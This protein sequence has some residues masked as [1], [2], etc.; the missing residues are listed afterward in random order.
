MKFFQRSYTL[1]RDQIEDTA[2]ERKVAAEGIPKNVQDFK[3]HPIYV[4][5]RH[6]KHNEV[7]YP[8]TQVGRVN[9]GTAM[10]PNIEPIY[11]RS[12]VHIVHTAD[13]WYRMGRDVKSGAQPLK[14][15][16]PKR[17]RRPSP[18]TEMEDDRKMMEDENG[19]ALYAEFQTEIY[20]PPPVVMGRV[21]RNAYGNLDLFVPSM[22]PSGGTHIRHKLAAKASRI[23]AIDYA[24]AVTGFSFKGRHG[25]AILQGVVVAEC[26]ADAVVAVIDGLE[27]QIEQ[28]ERAA[29]QS[30]CLRLWRR[31][32]IG[33]GIK[34]RIDAIVID[35]ETG[36][37][38]DLQQQIEREDQELLRKDLAGGFVLEDRHVAEMES[39]GSKA[40]PPP[41]TPSH[42]YAGDGF[43]HGDNESDR[44]Y[45]DE[46]DSMSVPQARHGIPSLGNEYSFESAILDSQAL[47]PRRHRSLG[48]ESLSDKDSE[49]IEVFPHNSIDDNI[50][51]NECGQEETYQDSSGGRDRKENSN[52]AVKDSATADDF[53]EE[54]GEKHMGFPNK[55]SPSI[56]PSGLSGKA[57]DNMAAISPTLNSSPSSELGSLLLEDPEDEDADPDWLVDIT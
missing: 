38:L 30:E 23:L 43:I 29:K 36:P 48:S 24:D 8:L 5:E 49:D 19:V 40:L 4:L 1:D 25:T 35:G 31:F 17:G 50:D 16:K 3:G 47:R 10:S 26:Y 7:I 14:Y 52:E 54:N 46:S 44:V 37:Q 55:V 20:I 45:Q 13:K 34:Q 28:A 41:P 18:S 6:L 33:L 27:L 51:N 56:S 32:L 12:N 42:G 21:P 2:L 57:E 22:C 53:R 39:E 9:C 15:T 11:R